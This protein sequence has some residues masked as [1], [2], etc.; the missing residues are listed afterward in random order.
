MT[1]FRSTTGPRATRE[2]TPSLSV[3]LIALVVAPL[4]LLG[5]PALPPALR[6][7]SISW[8]GGLDRWSPDRGDTADELLHPVADLVVGFDTCR[9][10]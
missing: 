1:E 4:L 8:G 7:G 5:P 9:L 2:D 10:S 6:I 3:S